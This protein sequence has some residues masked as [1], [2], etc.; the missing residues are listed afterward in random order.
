LK[1]DAHRLVGSSFILHLPLEKFFLSSK[2][3]SVVFIYCRPSKIGGQQSNYRFRRG[4]NYTP[5][6]IRA[7]GKTNT[8]EFMRAHITGSRTKHKLNTHEVYQHERLSFCKYKPQWRI[9]VEFFIVDT[10]RRGAMRFTLC[11]WFNLSA[12]A[13]TAGLRSVISEVQPLCSGPPVSVGVV[14]CTNSRGF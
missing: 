13:I 5:W 11:T 2:L 14:N 3:A 12:P 6:L 9:I 10:T 1:P 8:S 7:P 4:S